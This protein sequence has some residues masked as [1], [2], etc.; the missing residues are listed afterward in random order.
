MVTGVTAS[1]LGTFLLPLTGFIFG[2]ATVFLVLLFTQTM[3]SQM[4][5][6]TVVLVGMIMTL[7]VGAI[8]TLITAL[9]Q[10]YLKQLVF[11]QMGSFSGSNWQK[12]A[13]YCPILLVSSLFLWFDA[14]ALD[15][16]GLGEEHAM[17]AGVEV[18]T[19]KLRI[20][21]LAS[22]LA[23]SAVSFVGVIGFV[24]LIAPHI[25]RR[26]LGA[27]HRLIPGSAILGGTIM[28]IGDTIA[29]TIL[30]PR[31]IPIGAVTALIGA[32]FFLYIY[33]KKGAFFA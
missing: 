21:L 16:L 26:Y 2:L 25:V 14:N 29:R 24:D 33:F 32:P 7:F 19:A 1:I 22:L 10:D 20:I 31:E 18:K 17:L 3:D 30:S 27:T 4:S 8:L 9:F 11:W 13:I 15:V 5:N 6:Q 12:I 28:V 23:G